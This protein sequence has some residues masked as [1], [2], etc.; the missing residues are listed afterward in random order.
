[1]FAVFVLC[2]L[3]FVCLFAACG[4]F[5]VVGF[6]FCLLFDDLLYGFC[7]FDGFSRFLFN[8]RFNLFALIL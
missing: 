2:V 3:G 7:W 4:L 1:M 5:G 8:S 6:V